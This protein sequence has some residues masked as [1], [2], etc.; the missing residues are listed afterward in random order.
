MLGMSGLELQERLRELDILLP[1]VVMTAYARTPL[2]V[3]AMRGGA[4]TLLEKP[5]EEDELWDAIRNALAQDA[6]DRATHERRRRLR[7]RIESLTPAQRKVMDR[8]VAGKANKV[9]A[10]ELDVSIPTVEA[11]RQE[12]FSRMQADSVA[13]LVRLTIEAGPDG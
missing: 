10:M 12:V 9:I 4:M 1:V 2:T 13:E 7:H 6:K 11:R 8:I 3:R 5:C